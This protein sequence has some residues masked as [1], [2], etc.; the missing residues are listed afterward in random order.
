[1]IPFAKAYS[2]LTDEEMV[3]VD[4]IVKKTTLEKFGPVR[5]VR[6]TLVFELGFEGIQ[7]STRH[8]SGIATRF[9]RMLRWRTDKTIDE[10]D[11]LASLEALMD[12]GT[13]SVP[14]VPTVADPDGHDAVVDVARGR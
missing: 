12:G 9:P 6:P 8:K 14:A 4:A 2:G 1:L 11:T 7:R 5:S 10:A 3:Q 13:E